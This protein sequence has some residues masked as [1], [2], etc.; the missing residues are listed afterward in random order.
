MPQKTLINNKN[1][2]DSVFIVAEISANHGRDFKRAMKMIKAAKQCGADAVKFQAYTP[3]TL[4][5]DIDN[6][7]FRIRH[8]RW[9]NQTLYQLYKKAYAPWSWFRR[10]KKYAEDTGLIFFATAFDRK[11]VDLLEELDVPFH[12]IASFEL[13]DLPLIEYAAKTKKPIILSTGM[14][15]ISEIKDAVFTAKRGGA[16]YVILLKCVSGYPARPEDMNL[17]AIPDM[18]KRFG[19]HIGL[20]D[21]THGSDVAV[22]AVSLGAI[23]VEKHFTLSRKLK[24]PDSFFSIEPGEFKSMVSSIRTVEKALGNVRYGLT[25]S[26]KDSRIFRRSI[27][28]VRN[29]AE[30]ENITSDNVRVIRPAYGI[31]PKHLKNILGKKANVN[32]KKGTPLQWRALA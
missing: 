12:K 23:M 22:A 13:V 24:T 9:G 14:S 25:K 4:T 6:K 21:H 28:A 20:S 26:E 8:P 16:K 11:S 5:I 18:I 1:F 15:T 17:K 3:D 31:M 7:Y 27:F 30:G 29:I 2:H 19:P 10:L 32:I